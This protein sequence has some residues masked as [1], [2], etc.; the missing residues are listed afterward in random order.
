MWCCELGALG[1][2]WRESRIGLGDPGHER[3]VN[4]TGTQGL[5]CN[6]AIRLPSV[7]RPGFEA[8]YR[9][10][11]WMGSFPCISCSSFCYLCLT[12]FLSTK[13]AF[14]GTLISYSCISCSFFCYIF[15]LIFLSTIK[16]VFIGTPLTL[17]DPV[18]LNIQLARLLESRRAGS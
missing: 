16:H 8:Q 3:L 12:N 4:F 2:R 7:R 11:P 15:L 10:T 13:H 6:S 17:L 9:T 18:D 14:I 1:Y 5:F